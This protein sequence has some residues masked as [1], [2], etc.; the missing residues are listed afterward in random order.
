[1]STGADDP[2]D[3]ITSNT[4]RGFTDQEHLDDFGL[5]HMNGRIYDPQIGKFTS[6]DPTTSRPYS[7]QGLN[8]YAYTENNPLNAT[9]PTGFATKSCPNSFVDNNCVDD[10]GSQGGSTTSAPGE[11]PAGSN[12]APVATAGNSATPGS[13][14]APAAPSGGE[15]GGKAVMT[16]KDYYRL[17]REYHS[18]LYMKYGAARAHAMEQNGGPSPLSDALAQ[19]GVALPAA[20]DGQSSGQCKPQCTADKERFF[21]WLVPTAKRMA[22]DTDTTMQLILT[23]AVKEGGWDKTG[24]DHNQPLNNPF[25]VNKIEH[26]K[27][28][29]NVK[30][31][32]L[33][34]AVKAWEAMY[35]QYVHGAKDPGTFVQ[36]LLN[37]NYNTVNPNYR[38]EFEDRY[39]DVGCAMKACGVQK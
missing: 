39:K 23:Q 26:R 13:A 7:T 20:T 4:T 33:D 27:A 35:D 32:S 5:I 15:V 14:Q 18:A 9:D 34:D 3:A 21:T 10:S 1:V 22:S 19:A 36:D 2:N 28:V 12:Q 24:L 6:A 30:Y 17:E 11:G 38:Q 29:G 31:A 37:H 25:G 8:R 16:K